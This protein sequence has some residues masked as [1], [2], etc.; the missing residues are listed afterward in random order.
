MP[1]FSIRTGT[2][3]NF[4]KGIHYKNSAKLKLKILYIRSATLEYAAWSYAR[5]NAKGGELNVFGTAA[6]I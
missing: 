6:A 3:L 2:I 4:V 5:R 1:G